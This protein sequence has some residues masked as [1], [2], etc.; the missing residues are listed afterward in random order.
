[1][2]DPK[3]YR[4]VQD[5]LGD[6]FVASMREF[7]GEDL[8]DVATLVNGLFKHVGDRGHREAI[9]R[10]FYEGR[11]IYK[12]GLALLVQDDAQSAHVR[13]QAFSYGTVCEG[14]LSDVAGFALSK[15]LFRGQFF[16]FRDPPKC[17]RP[18][19]PGNQHSFHNLILIAEEEKV[20]DADLAKRLHGL[21]K[22]RNSVHSRFAA[23]SNPGKFYV[24]RGKRYFQTVVD[25]VD[26]TK[27]WKATQAAKL[28][29]GKP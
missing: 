26:A 19:K 13:P 8:E 20:I 2:S 23:N 28:A 16:R 5:T 6:R 14:L 4:E 11:W 21:R 17:T 29:K 25:L 22:D 18:T 9:A 3:T 7:I 15:G 27:S 24:D 12:A 10:A 1:M